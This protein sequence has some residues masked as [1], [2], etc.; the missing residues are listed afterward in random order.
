MWSKLLAVNGRKWSADG[1]HEAIAAAARSHEPIELLVT[2]GD[3]FTT[4]RVA[5]YGGNR[6]PHLERI[7]GTQDLLERIYTPRTFGPKE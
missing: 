1:L 2:N 4:A 5:A 7:A 3:F 6:Y